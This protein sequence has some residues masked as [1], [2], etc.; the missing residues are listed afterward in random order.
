[1]ATI[2]LCDWTKERLGKEEKSYSVVIEGDQFEVGEAGLKAML[3]QLEGEDAP[4]VG[5]IREKIVYREA[6]PSPLAAAPPGID[7]EVTG[8]PF[9]PGPGSAPQP[10]QGNADDV[11]A[12]N[13]AE[14]Q[15][16]DVIPLEIPELNAKTRLKMPTSAQ[17]D[18]VIQ[19]STRFE[20]GGLPSLTMGGKRQKEAMRKLRAIEEKKEQEL[21]RSAHKGINVGGDVRSKPGFYGE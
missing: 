16:G 10:I 5:P 11:S 6:P 8:D 13:T 14:A 20:E 3:E 17:A 4:E 2:R 9:E 7:V 19:E 12:P 21:K 1:M 18:K 15:T